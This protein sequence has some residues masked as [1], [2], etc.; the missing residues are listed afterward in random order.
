MGVMLRPPSSQPQQQQQ[1]PQQPAAQA[2][3]TAAAASPSQAAPTHADVLSSARQLEQM[4]RLPEANRSYL[5][6]LQRYPQHVGCLHRL[7]VVNTRMNDLE[8]ARGYFDRALRLS[9][10]NVPLLT[11]A[12][13]SRYLAGDYQQA[14]N[15]LRRA[16]QLAPQD[17]RATNNLAVV[18]GVSGRFNEALG[19]F[20]RANKPAAAW[21]NLAYVYQLRKEPTHALT[22][23]ERA[24]ALDATIQVPEQLLAQS[25]SSGA[26]ISEGEVPPSPVPAAA[27]P[28]MLR[29]AAA[30][31][32][33]TMDPSIAQ[34][35]IVVDAPAPPPE[36]AAWPVVTPGL[37]TVQAQAPESF[38]APAATTEDPFETPLE[39]PALVE[40][41]DAEPSPF[42]APLPVPAE[43]APVLNPVESSDAEYIDSEYAKLAARAGWE[44]FK[45]FCLVTLYEE[46]RLV[47]AQSEFAVVYQGQSYQ[48]ASS[49]AAERFQM[50]PNRYV[51]AAGGLDVVAVLRGSDV[52]PGSL[53]YAV[54]Y[55]DR[56]YMFSSQQHKNEFRASP[57]K[58]VIE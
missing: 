8:T 4:G 17:V 11:D 21:T 22:C 6:V 47:D 28:Q 50:E 27:L 12:G 44:G 1:Q 26:P 54:W 37:P 3:S 10:E 7:A 53:D 42:E 31:P 5:A 2:A 35:S 46:R 19:L 14:E 48:F 57:R 24:R 38:A 16:T 45:G 55:R 20:Q 15:L 41:R 36:A 34:E 13:Y 9:Q 39:S 52:I 18:V 40:I 30:L 32:T 29:P 33:V 56:L 25:A 23:Y 51:P 49:D 43:S 58:F